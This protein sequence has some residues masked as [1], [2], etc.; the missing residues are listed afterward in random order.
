MLLS[1]AP[2]SPTVN[3]LGSVQVYPEY[4]AIG[5]RYYKH[6]VCYLSSHKV[7]SDGELQLDSLDVEDGEVL[8]A[9]GKAGGSPVDG[10]KA[11]GE[12]K[13]HLFGVS[14]VIGSS[15]NSCSCW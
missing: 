9:A 5:K 6:I 13:R 15:S 11:V 3:V 2:C 10:R 7:C 4:S 1:R 8:S 14:S 12:I